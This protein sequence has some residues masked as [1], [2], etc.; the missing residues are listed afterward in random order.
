[1]GDDVATPRPFSSGAGDG[2]R[3]KKRARV[4]SRDHPIDF[5]LENPLDGKFKDMPFI[6]SI[7]DGYPDYVFKKPTSYCHYGFAY[8]KRTVFIGTLH[9]FNP[10]M[11]CRGN[12]CSVYK[13]HR[14][15][16][17]QVKG[18]SAADKNSI[19]SRLVD[20]EVAAWVS[21]YPD[22]KHRFLFIDVFAGYGSVSQHIRDKYPNIH[23]YAN[24][25]VKR[26]DNNVELDMNKF[27]TYFLFNLALQ[28]F[29]GDPM[30]PDMPQGLVQWLRDE[31]IA[32][33][34]HVSSPCNTYSIDGLGP[35]RDKITL[36]PK[37]ELAR[38]HD[39]MNSKLVEW[40]KQLCL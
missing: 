3:P 33:L 25:I 4:P 12:P 26:K 1:M 5:L 14:R 9:K 10:A 19:P 31:K 37:S 16:A 28:R 29:F 22:P 21:K 13:T 30:L 2:F 20:L 24:D 18:Q 7:V 17:S 23:V 39:E 38:Q 32:V 40:L 34:I 36:E 35:N 8:M 6:K 27:P 11:P 15:H